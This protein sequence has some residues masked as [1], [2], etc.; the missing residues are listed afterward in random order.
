MFQ[1]HKHWQLENLFL[2]LTTPIS[3][4]KKML[5]TVSL[6]NSHLPL[7]YLP[8][9]EHGYSNVD[10]TLLVVRILRLIFMW[11]Q[12]RLPIAINIYEISF[13][14]R[15]LSP[16]PQCDHFYFINIWCSACHGELSHSTAIPY[17]SISFAVHLTTD[18]DTDTDTIELENL[19]SISNYWLQLQM[20]GKSHWTCSAK[21]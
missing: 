7:P 5:Q 17:G 4:T 13:N 6:T 11:N 9:G 12:W 10:Q 2:L 15:R 21:L 3:H 18:T 20:P 8:Q 14:Y 16:I 19:T 1:T